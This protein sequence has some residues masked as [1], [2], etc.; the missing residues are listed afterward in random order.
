MIIIKLIILILIFN[1]LYIYFIIII[2]EMIYNKII[3]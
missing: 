3:D 1:L 2:D